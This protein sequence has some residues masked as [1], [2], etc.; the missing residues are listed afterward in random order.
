MHHLERHLPVKP[1]VRG[2]ING[3]DAAM[4]YTGADEI[5]F[6]E[7]PADERV[8]Q[9][10]IHY[11]TLHRH[12]RKVIV[13]Q[14]FVLLRTCALTDNGRCWGGKHSI[15]PRSHAGVMGHGHS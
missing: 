1:G 5:T 6:V 2:E 4:S 15:S 10:R 14:I 11:C 7:R 12:V 13:T 8:R 3:G 9:S